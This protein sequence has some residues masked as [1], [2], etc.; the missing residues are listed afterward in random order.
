MAL[1]PALHLGVP[2]EA[3]LRCDPFWL[4]NIG[5]LAP[6]FAF[7]WGYRDQ[8]PFA[9]WVAGDGVLS[10]P[11][12]RTGLCFT[13]GVDSFHSLLRGQHAVNY[14]VFVHGFDMPL[15]DTVRMG[16]FADV[17]RRVA[18]A[19]GAT[20]L[21]VR[22]NLREHPIF[23]AVSWDR[24]HSAALAAVGH[25]L[26]GVMDRLVIASS[27]SY[28]F[29]HP[30]GS[31]WQTDPLWSGRSLRIVHDAPH[32]A[33]M[34]KVPEIAAE[35]LLWDNL[36]VC[37]ENRAPAGNCS[38]CE[39]CLRTMVLLAASEKLHHYRV[40]DTA[41]PLPRLL[42]RLPA[43]SARLVP[44]WETL[45]RKHPDPDVRA[46]IDRLAAQPATTRIHDSP[47]ATSQ[48]GSHRIGKGRLLF[49]NGLIALIFGLSLVAV[50]FRR[51]LWPFRLT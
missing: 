20:P 42:D 23:G 29:T 43:I 40:F 10:P 36:R 1:L 30:W 45:A 25:L 22:T 9:D 2:V 28:Q 51:E 48:P 46:A 49:V 34:D 38:R 35:P 21:V 24:T 4:D 32:L 17:L 7:W 18:A 27:F 16:E 26:S 39:K 19:T 5:Q 37:W 11:A 33:R 31:H 6:I 8:F 15:A 41:T 14:L 50:A 47:R 3:D 44:R 13:G 12:G